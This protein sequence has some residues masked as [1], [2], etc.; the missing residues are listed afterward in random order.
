MI[1]GI[2][3]GLTF[4]DVLLLPGKSSVLP[5]QA[6]T[7]TCLSR[8]IA[9]NIPIVAAAMDTV[10]ESRLAVALARQGGI[11][12][13]HRNMSIERQAEEVDKVKRSE[14]GMIVD[15]VTIAP[16]MSVRQ[17]LEIM[18]KYKVSGLPVTRGPKLVGILTNRDLRFERNLDQPV[19]EVMTKDNLVTVAVGTTLEEAEKILQKHRIEKLLVVDKEYCLKGLITVKD[20]QKKMEFPLA[21]KDDH[22]RL[23][24]GGAIGATG[25]FLE[26]AQELAR[27]KADLLAIDTAHGHTTRVMDAIRAVKRKLP[28]VQLVAGNVATAEG[29]KDLIALGVDGLKVGIG[30]GSICT[31]R[32]VTGI[33]VPQITAIMECATAAKGTGVPVIA[34]GGIK[35]SGDITK[36]LAAGASS[37]MIGGLFAG[38]EESPGETILY[39]GRT[40]KSYRGMGSIGAMEAGSADRYAQEGADRGKSVPEGIEGQ[41]PY[42]GPLGALVEQ[43]VGGLRSGMGY[44]GAANLNE[45]QEKSQFVRISQAGLRE[46][47]VHDVIITREAPNYR[48]E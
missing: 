8:R 10:T 41:V 44:T 12:F 45:L 36:A 7:R 35:F 17:A 15:P 34:D 25:D 13:I 42:K 27:E 40:F 2:P 16:E 24:V 21:T 14:S 38:T 9:I 31:T 46:S 5:A 11:G 23:R 1:D 47:H 39:Q 33:G 26:R 20:I 37:V 6:D 32:I 28:D 18:T 43:L 30:P 3:Q 19:S 22:G 29:T 4:D 48:L